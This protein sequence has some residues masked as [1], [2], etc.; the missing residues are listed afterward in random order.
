[1]NQGCTG[2]RLLALQALI[3]CQRYEDAR[4]A[5]EQ[6]PPGVDRLYLEAQTAWRAGDLTAAKMCLDQA[7]SARR[8]ST[9]CRQLLALVSELA[10][11]LEA[12]DTALNDGKSPFLP[13][14]ALRPEPHTQK[15][16]IFLCTTKT[17]IYRS[18]FLLARP[19]PVL[20]ASATKTTV[21]TFST[22]LLYTCRKDRQAEL[23][24]FWSDPSLR[25][26]N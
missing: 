4:A 12:V 5:C 2:A 9:K 7:M 26:H 3:F 8:D 19:R 14:G 15:D 13:S 11:K 16:L 1:M 24:L 22:R 25:Y 21:P 18:A 23:Q 6:L 17:C 10:C 20:S